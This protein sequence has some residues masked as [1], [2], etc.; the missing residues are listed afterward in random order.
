M[1]ESNLPLIFLKEV[2]L[3][4]FN[5]V[6]IEVS[7]NRDKDII[8]YSDNNC[9]GYLLCINLEDDKEENPEINT[10]P[11]IGILGKIKSKIE[12]PNGVI[13]LVLIGI[14]RVEVLNYSEGDNDI[15]YA[16]I[17][18]TKEYDYSLEEA[19]ALKRVLLKNLDEYIEISPYVSN[20]VLGRING[21]NNISRLSD[22]IVY[23][24]PMDYSNKLKYIKIS[25]S[26][27]R[28]R[29][30]VEDLNKEIETVKL[31]TEI[32]S[33]LKDKLDNEQ[34]NYILREKIKL[35]KEELGED[36][37]RDNEINAIKDKLNNGNYPIHIKN[38]IINE[39][40]R[41]SVLTENEPEVS[42]IRNYI[43]WLVNLPYNINT[44]D[45]KDIESVRNHLDSSH[46]GLNEIKDRIIEYL[47]VSDRVNNAPIICL[48]GPPGVGKSTMAKSIAEALNKKFVKLSVGGL[49]DSS[50]LIG[51]RKTYIGSYPGKII[52][53]LRKCGCNNPLFLIDEVDKININSKGDPSSVL[54]D[55]LDKEQ[56]NKFQDNYLEEE[57]DLSNVMFMLTAND[58]SAIPLALRDRL[59]IIN[60]SSYT[61]N[62]KVA[63]ALNHIIP[64]LKKEYLISSVEFSKEALLDIINYYTKESGVRELEREISKIFRKIILNND[65]NSYL[66]DDVTLYLGNYKYVQLG[67]EKCTACGVVNMLGYTPYGGIIL[68]CTASH[69]NGNGHLIL[70]GSLGEE[71]KESASVVLSYIKENSHVFGLDD[72]KFNDDIHIH[73]E[74]TG[75]KKDGFSGGIALVTTLISMYKK[76]CI[77]NTIGM[78]G[79]M[80]LR[81]KILP[82]SGLREKLIAASINGIKT[83]YLPKDNKNEVME[84]D[85]EITSKLKIK[86]VDDYIEIY[87]DLFKE[88]K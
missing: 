42:L 22:I 30:L 81:G 8:N 28:L 84:F 52:Q 29:L 34:K 50:T 68:K 6:R 65:N 59:E 9:N 16:F 4:P 46:Y 70:T 53:L 40:K 5:E 14:D 33:N 41:Y 47:M 62:E 86:Y 3:L 58:I 19:N 37:L 63:I 44:E 45:N 20:N 49:D 25:S 26:I 78:T 82:V 72:N 54:L 85:S 80:T 66:I 18:P 55:I 10:L 36:N 61:V 15:I 74:N 31:E 23:E 38:R 51:H 56:N 2:V 83:V 13:R 75:M 35:I 24:L 12:L 87:D 76:K 7:S 48:I 32:E 1:V 77:S 64:K 17:I 73:I 67:N 43:D 88:K 71:I 79:E 39:L 60:I 27:S 69:Y 11:K 57:F 21:I